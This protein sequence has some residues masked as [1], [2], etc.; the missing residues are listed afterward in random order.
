MTSQDQI[1]PELLYMANEESQFQYSALDLDSSSPPQNPPDTTTIPDRKSWTWNY[2]TMV[3]DK[4]VKKWKCAVCPN[5]SKAK[6]YTVSSGTGKFAGI[7]FYV[8]H[9]IS[10]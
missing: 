2:G 5:P 4:G 8:I 7:L 10:N 1:D 9:N 6:I 3:I